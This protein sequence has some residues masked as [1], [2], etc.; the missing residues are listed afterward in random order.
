M[1]LAGKPAMRLRSG[2]FDH[3]ATQQRV[4]MPPAGSRLVAAFVFHFAFRIPHSAFRIP[5]SAF[6][7][8]HFAFRIPHFALRTWDIP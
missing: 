4:A 2:R 1:Q 5:H 7:T 8:P 3:M 6:R